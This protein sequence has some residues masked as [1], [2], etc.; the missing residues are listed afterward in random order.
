[1][2][3]Y[4]SLRSYHQADNREQQTLI[5]PLN[6]TIIIIL[7]SVDLQPVLTRLQVVVG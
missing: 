2:Q 4:Y 6:E 3:L 5:N 7:I 1:M